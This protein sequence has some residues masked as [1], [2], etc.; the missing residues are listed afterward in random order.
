MRIVL[1]LL[2]LSILAGCAGTGPREVRSGEIYLRHAAEEQT[3]S[4]MYSSIRGWRPAGDDAVLIEFNRNRYYLFELA[5]PC[6]TEIRFAQSIALLTSTS[7]RVDRF[8]RI[9]VGDRTCRIERIREV[10]FEA[11]RAE[12]EALGEQ[13]EPASNPVEVETSE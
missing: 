4:V 5:P 11:A 6:S 8:D 13:P 1:F 9:R 7:Q 10:D 12:I 3:S 2:M